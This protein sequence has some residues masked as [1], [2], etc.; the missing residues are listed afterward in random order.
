MEFVPPTQSQRLA[1]IGPTS[2][3]PAILR[4][5]FE[6][7]EAF[8]P[9]P[10]PGPGDWLANHHEVG[11]TFGQFARLGAS[12]PDAER[13]VLYLQPL[14]EFGGTAPSLDQLRRFSAALTTTAAVRSFRAAS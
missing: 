14:G 2:Q 6:S 11:Q 3:L 13:R 10:R 8:Q 4:R 7:G 5:A 12:R 9:M 1:A